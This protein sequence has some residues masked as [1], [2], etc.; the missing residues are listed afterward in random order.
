MRRALPG[1][2]WDRIHAQIPEPEV[3]GYDNAMGL[4]AECRA[5]FEGKPSIGKAHLDATALTFRG[6]FRLLIPFKDLTTSEAKGSQL[7]LVWTEGEAIF[8]L[9]SAAEKWLLKI[10]HPRSRLEKLGIKDGMKVCALG[11]E[12]EELLR[13]A[14]T[15]LTKESDLIFLAVRST[16]DLARLPSLIAS[17]KP[18]GAIWIVF[19]KGQKQ[20]KD[21]DV[22]S[23]GRAAGLVDT[24]VVSFSGTH[25]A[26][27]WMIPVAQRPR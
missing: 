4:E 12:D 20:L 27:K 5:W 24:K 18:A 17:L 8:E 10:R 22:R 25:S 23:A 15:R 14:R 26:L 3:L 9:G 1:H 21:S 11:I 16:N 7:R 19:P 6:G 2:E 13:H